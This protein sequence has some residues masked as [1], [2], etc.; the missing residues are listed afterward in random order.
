MP[1]NPPGNSNGWFPYACANQPMIAQEQALEFM[2]FD[3]TSCVAPDNAQPPGPPPYKSATF[4]QDFTGT[5]P[6]G[7]SIAWREF[8][9]QADVPSGTN[10]AFAAQSGPNSSG[11][12][13]A[14]PVALA[15][16]TTS[17]NLPTYDAVIID[18]ST[19]GTTTGTAPF[20]KAS[21]P[22]RSDT[23]LRVTITMNPDTNG[24]IT[25]VLKSW[26]VQYDCTASQ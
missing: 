2:F 19:G 23:L 14:T 3:L 4:T 21:P 24:T 22:I 11:L 8:D 1:A 9:W 26:K 10:I 17:T 16:A 6:S 13:N 25:P 7:Q 15:T 12:L 5:C 20:N 18:T